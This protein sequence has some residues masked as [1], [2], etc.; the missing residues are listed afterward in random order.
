M[1]NGFTLPDSPGAIIVWLAVLLV[2]LGLY[3]LIRR[4]HRRSEQAYFDRKRRDREA[5]AA[6][7]DMRRPD[8]AGPA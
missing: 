3:T 2:I 6:D 8:D 5:R 1:E 7:P 4:T